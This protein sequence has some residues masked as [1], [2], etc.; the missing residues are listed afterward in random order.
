MSDKQSD[1]IRSNLNISSLMTVA[2]LVG[3]WVVFFATQRAELADHDRRIVVL[4]TE[5]VPRSEHN[6]TLRVEAE[7]EKLL[8]ERLTNIERMLEQMLSRRID[9]PR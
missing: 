1:W 2:V 8:D 5:I 6:A 3:G 4:E 7:K 9:A